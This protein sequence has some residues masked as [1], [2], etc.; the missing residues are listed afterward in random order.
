V[1]QTEDIVAVAGHDPVL[2]EIDDPLDAS[3]SVGFAEDEDPL[4]YFYKTD[5]EPIEHFLIL[6][7]VADVDKAAE[8]ESGANSELVNLPK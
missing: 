2:V 5:F 6:D 3:S 1:E 4:D 8:E 7:S